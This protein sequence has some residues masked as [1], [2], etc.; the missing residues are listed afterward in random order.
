MIFLRLQNNL[1]LEFKCISIIMN[2]SLEFLKKSLGN[3][4]RL[5][6]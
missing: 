5:R 1:N 2:I 6:V 4:V 3:E